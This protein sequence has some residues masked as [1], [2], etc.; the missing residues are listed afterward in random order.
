MDITEGYSWK[1]DVVA[2]VHGLFGSGAIGL[3][4][5]DADGNAERD[6]CAYRD[7]LA[8]GCWIVVDDYCGSS[9]KTQPTREQIDA[10]CKAG[11]L[12]P[13]GVYGWGTWVGRL[14]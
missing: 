9:S 11:K 14:A 13:L 5:I 12:L 6:L 3:F 7:L 1:R 10:L 4:F 2:R 8:A